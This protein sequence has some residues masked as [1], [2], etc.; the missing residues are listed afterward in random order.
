M[1]FG[2]TSCARRPDLRRWHLQIAAAFGLMV[3]AV[4]F[5]VLGAGPVSAAGLSD[6][7]ALTK[8]DG[9]I[10]VTDDGAVIENLEIFGTL[11]IEAKDVT[12]RNVWV[13]GSSAWLI[14]VPSGSAR[15]E[16]VELGHPSY[17]ASRG[18]GGSNIVATGLDI[19]D[20]EDGIKLGSNS[21]YSNVRVHDLNSPD[22]SPHYDAVQVESTVSNATVKNSYLSSLGPGGIGNAAVIVMTDF[23]P[24]SNITFS[25]NYMNGGNYTIFVRDGGNGVPSNV[26]FEGNRF[27]RT[28]NYGLTSLDGPVGWENNTWADTGETIDVQGN[29]IGQSSPT[30]TTTTTKVPEAST[31]TT[32]KAPEATTTTTTKAP[33]TT[34]TTA[35]ISTTV[36][37]TTTTTGPIVALAAPPRAPGTDSSPD[38]PI[39]L[40][41]VAVVA[42]A[43]AL[44]SLVGVG[45]VRRMRG[46]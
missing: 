3:T 7:S 16:N 27:G 36:A 39:V 44:L 26:I 31:T 14:Y 43:L 35:P 20:V 5:V 28:S 45:V 34:T 24:Q 6:P 18:I 15:I 19:H 11:R 41:A 32:T 4:V 17:P 33:P 21:V 46:T 10:T 25:N 12:V 42:T 9:S 29:V 22:S 38:G 30:T 40:G 8:H 23:G 2:N 37:T 13:Y 1:T